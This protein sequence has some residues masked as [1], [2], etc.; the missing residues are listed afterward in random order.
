MLAQAVTHTTLAAIEAGIDAT[1]NQGGYSFAQDWQPAPSSGYFVGLEGIQVPADDFKPSTVLRFACDHAALLYA[2][3]DT[4]VV[5]TWLDNGIVY[6]D[7][8]VR[9]DEVDAAMALAREHQQLA[10]Y[11][12]DSGQTLPVS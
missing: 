1:F 5:G 12:A 8:T 4:A 7:V 9:V 3:G 6:I 11:H 2:H 10:V